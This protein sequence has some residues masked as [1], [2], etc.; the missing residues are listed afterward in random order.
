MEF[1]KG[2]MTDRGF[3]REGAVITATLTTGEVVDGILY[4]PAKKQFIIVMPD[5]KRLIEMT[6]VGDVVEKI[7]E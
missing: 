1:V 3:I 4:K 7:A 5:L 2:L 6:E